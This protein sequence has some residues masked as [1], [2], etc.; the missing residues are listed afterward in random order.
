ME[1]RNAE[2]QTPVVCCVHVLSHAPFRSMSAL[3]KSSAVVVAA[4]VK[5]K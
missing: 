3:V 5:D 2:E 4:L 1:A